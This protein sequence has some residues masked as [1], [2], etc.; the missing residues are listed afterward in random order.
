MIS[1]IQITNFQSLKEVEI[2][3]GNFTVI[4]GESD[5]GKSAIVRAISALVNNKTGQDF[6]KRGTSGCEISLISGDDSVTWKKGKSASYVL[7]G[8]TFEKMG[9]SVP[10][11]IEEV[12]SM[13]DIDVGGVRFQPNFHSQFSVPFLV[14]E[15]GSFRAK[16]LGELS[17]TNVLF[18]AAQE[19]RRREQSSKRLRVIRLEDKLKL[20]S[21][22]EKFSYLKEWKTRLVKC[23]SLL[24]ELEV[25][26]ENIQKIGDILEHSK[27]LS[28]LLIEASKS[29][30]I[31]DKLKTV[32]AKAEKLVLEIQEVD[33]CIENIIDNIIDL[34]YSLSDIVVERN[35]TKGDLLMVTKEIEGLGVCPTCGRRLG[36]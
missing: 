21:E 32:I 25:L 19:A 22:L 33:S 28:S 5:L 31:S 35:V 29:L 1:K 15:T 16:I 30:R 17:G 8:K 10:E 2:E 34:E 20:D 9:S 23:K 26:E 3:P 7:N 18:T 12:L 4:L 13:G 11:E 24:A 14:G 6:I 27:S 36:V